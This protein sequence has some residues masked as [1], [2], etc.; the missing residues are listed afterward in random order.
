MA[1][2]RSY[3]S[4]PFIL[5]VLFFCLSTPAVAAAD[6][7]E[8]TC[9]SLPGNFQVAA[10]YREWIV[11]LIARSPTL[12]RQCLAI[13]GAPGVHVLMDSTRRLVGLD[14]ART[15]F[16]RDRGTLS[17]TVTIPMTR[18][19][20]EL[21]AHELE[22]VLEQIEG[23]NLRR[24]AQVRDSGVRAVGHNVF[25]TARAF[26]AGR[27][28]VRETHACQSGADACAS[29]VVLVAAAVR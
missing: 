7:G 15:S 22:H 5:L 27:A 23:V 28:A 4:Y 18:D 24:L 16:V 1:S 9:A 19:F 6:D 26:E 8:A 29:R 2:L 12:T 11:D 10:A 20:V 25:E 13:A 3:R 21:L 17:A 14:R